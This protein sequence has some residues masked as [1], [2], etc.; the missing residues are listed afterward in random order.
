MT[1]EEISIYVTNELTKF[2]VDKKNT[3]KA[4][5]LVEENYI[6]LQKEGLTEDVTCLVKTTFPNNVQISLTYKGE[7]FDPFKDMPIWTDEEDMLPMAI[8]KANRSRLAYTYAGRGYSSVIITVKKK[9]KSAIRI[10]LLSMILGVIV[11]ILIK[12]LLGE[13]MANILNDNI[14]AL[15]KNVFMNVLKMLI[16]PVIVFSL[17]SSIAGMDD[18]GSLGRIGA[19]IFIA[20]VITSVLSISIGMLIG[21]LTQG[22]F[23]GKSISVVSDYVAQNSS[24]AFKFNEFI[25]GIFPEDI[26]SPVAQGNMLQLLFISVFLGVMI[27]SIKKRIPRIVELIDQG[28]T[29]VIY[30]ITS[31]MKLMPVVAFCSM[32]TLIISTGV[33]TLVL[34]LGLFGLILLGQIVLMVLLP[35]FIPLVGKMNP[36]PFIKRMPDIMLTPFITSSSAAS[37]PNT[38]SV[39]RDKLGVKEE[40]VSLSVPIG[41]VINMN[42][43]CIML[44]ICFVI[45]NAMNGGSIGSAEVLAAGVMILVLSMGAPG[46]P[47][48]ALVC[49]SVILTNA[50]IPI[51]YMGLV[52]GVYPLISMFLTGVNVLGDCAVTVGLAGSEKM[53]DLTKYK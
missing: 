18:V 40:I 24:S 16:A 9:A 53:V 8:I 38:I 41:S 23:L 28:N 11:G 48:A 26:V 20:Y 52:V 35:I 31:I 13:N 39:C 14:F 36:L 49:L 29:L 50:S 4:I 51:E 43:S 32:A 12:M 25:L 44:S 17:V 46:I 30:M 6:F 45:M 7:K 19:K 21:Y 2:G 10:T 1:F 3:F 34:V 47:G 42:G 33:K 37:L 15:V 27:A 5:S 22:L